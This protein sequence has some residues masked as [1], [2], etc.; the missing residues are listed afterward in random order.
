MAYLCKPNVHTDSK[1]IKL[2]RLR[3]IIVG[4]KARLRANTYRDS[5]INV[6]AAQEGANAVLRMVRMNCNIDNILKEDGE[7]GNP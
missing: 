1:G 3:G 4:Q 2:A 5:I 7:R 6:D